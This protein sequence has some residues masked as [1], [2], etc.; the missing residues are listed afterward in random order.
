M[1]CSHL[2]PEFPKQSFSEIKYNLLNPNVK[3]TKSGVG[4]GREMPQ[5]TKSTFRKIAVVENKPTVVS[6][7][8]TL[9]G[10]GGGEEEQTDWLYSSWKV[11]LMPT[12]M[13]RDVV[14]DL[15]TVDLE[16][17]DSHLGREFGGSFRN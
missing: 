7:G 4:A 13:W 10:G 11:S 12:R 6:D 9:A 2:N 17:G 8:H 14:C 1:F 3:K 5:G 15:L 16:N